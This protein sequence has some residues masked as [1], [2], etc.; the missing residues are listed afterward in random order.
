[1]PPGTLSGMLVKKKVYWSSFLHCLASS[2]VSNSSPMGKPHPPRKTWWIDAPGLKGCTSYATLPTSATRARL[3]NSRI[4]RDSRK[5]AFPVP[6]HNFFA[7]FNAAPSEG[8]S[9]GQF[10][11]FVDCLSQVLFG[12]SRVDDEDVPLA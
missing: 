1:M 8:L 11:L 5:T 6:L 2:R 3:A 4:G 9:L 7:G 10:L 12:E